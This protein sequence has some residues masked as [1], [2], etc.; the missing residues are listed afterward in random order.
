MKAPLSE[1]RLLHQV[2]VI[3]DNAGL[4]L[5]SDLCLVLVLIEFGLAERVTLRVKA[6]PVFLSDVMEKDV[7]LHIKEMNQVSF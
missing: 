6:T 3:T 5:I 2:D 7:E 1:E 4:E